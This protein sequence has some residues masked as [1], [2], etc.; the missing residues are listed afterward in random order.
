M[1]TL[2]CQVLFMDIIGVRVFEESLIIVSAGRLHTVLY[3]GDLHVPDPGKV[4]KC[5]SHT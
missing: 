2:V 1:I 5:V 3:T 4:E